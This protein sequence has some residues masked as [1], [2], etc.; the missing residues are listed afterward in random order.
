MK[1]ASLDKALDVIVE[2]IASLDIDVV[3]KCELLINLKILLES[4]DEY[5]ASIDLL[6][7]R[8]GRR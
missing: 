8:G 4:V 6:S 7:R 2:G 1:Q 5:K 3:D